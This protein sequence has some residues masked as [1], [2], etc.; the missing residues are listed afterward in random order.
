M[1]EDNLT[2]FILEQL[3]IKKVPIDVTESGTVIEVKDEQESNT[4]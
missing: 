1:F 3:E 2:D 4:L